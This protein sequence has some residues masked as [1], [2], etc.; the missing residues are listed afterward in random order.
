[1]G[2]ESTREM[3]TDKEIE[4][5]FK[6]TSFGLEKPDETIKWSLL[7]TASSYSTGHTA[8]RIL[9]ELGLVTKGSR[10]ALTNRGRH[11][12]WVYFRAGYGPKEST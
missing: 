7:K 5:A 9:R 4:S 3:V 11:C 1:M 6:G 8:L 10:K 2:S 12:L